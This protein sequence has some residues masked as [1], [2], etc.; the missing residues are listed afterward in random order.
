MKN[1]RN[2]RTNQQ[3]AIR[4]AFPSG[5]VNRQSVT[6]IDKNEIYLNSDEKY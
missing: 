6:V 2:E 3:T 1:I 5:I 4:P